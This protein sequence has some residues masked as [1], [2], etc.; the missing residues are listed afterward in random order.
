MLKKSLDGFGY[1]DNINFEKLDT[2][3][4]TFSGH[5]DGNGTAA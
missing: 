2:D 5:I 4:L 3:K 1:K